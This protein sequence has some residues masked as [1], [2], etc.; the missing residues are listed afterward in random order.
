[1]IA[2]FGLLGTPEK[3]TI[4]EKV[5]IPA[6]YWHTFPDQSIIYPEYLGKPIVQVE[7]GKPEL[8]DTD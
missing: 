1:M 2:L 7:I 3:V 8:I 4:D 6:Q 5:K